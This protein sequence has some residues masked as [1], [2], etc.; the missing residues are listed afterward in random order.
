MRP[1]LLLPAILLALAACG[2]DATAIRDDLVAW[3]DARFDER[4]GQSP[5][6]IEP[7]TTLRFR[8]TDPRINYGR[9]ARLSKL[10][11]YDGSIKGTLT[12]AH[13]IA[14]KGK[15]YSLVQ[16]HFHSSSEHRVSG[17]QTPLEIHFVHRA[18]DGALAVI[19]VRFALGAANP[20]F[21]QLLDL[22]P[23]ADAAPVTPAVSFD[24]IQLLP[25]LSAPYFTYSGSLTTEPFSEQ[26]NWVV[27]KPTLTVSAAQYERYKSLFPEENSRGAQPLNGR[28]IFERVGE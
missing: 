12:G 8:S 7:A 11:R 17:A 16:F 24:L 1:V 3:P 6:D 2:D 28:F 15:S 18:S 13:S 23:A 26:L 4:G 5:I 19:G 25:A 27:F 21:E 9:V 22:A 20:V 14:I 10:E